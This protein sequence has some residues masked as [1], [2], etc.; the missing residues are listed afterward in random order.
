MQIELKSNCEEKWKS[1]M[2]VNVKTKQQQTKKHL[3]LII[4]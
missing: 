3:N 1:Y 4:Q 2:Y